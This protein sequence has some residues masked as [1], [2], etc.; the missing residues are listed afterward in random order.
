VVPIAWVCGFA[1]APEKMTIM[2]QNRTDIDPM[3]LP[4]ECRALKKS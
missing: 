4:F 3:Y 2:G 1:E